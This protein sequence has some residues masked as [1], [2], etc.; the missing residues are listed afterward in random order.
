MHNNC[1]TVKRVLP[2]FFFSD[3]ARENSQWSLRAQNIELA[4]KTF[5]LYRSLRHAEGN[6]HRID[7]SD[8]TIGDLY[9]S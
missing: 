6:L 2:H 9:P 5:L 7:N 4:G 1:F 8:L 3:P